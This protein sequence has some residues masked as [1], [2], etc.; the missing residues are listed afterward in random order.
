MFALSH[1]HQKMKSFMTFCLLAFSFTSNTN[2][3]ELSTELLKG[4]WTVDLT[5]SPG[6]DPY[7][8]EMAI[9]DT[10]E[11]SF[12]GFF[13]DTPFANGTVNTVWGK[14][15]FAFTTKDGSGK[16]F[17]TGYLEDGKIYGLTFSEGRK[18]V[19]PWTAWRKEDIS[20]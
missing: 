14:L 18:F 19:M 10:G 9:E 1:K 16:Y 11:N 2:A 3:Q 20:K 13:Y 8:K 6:A 15:Y 4:T 5:P 17:S 7:Y 12:Q